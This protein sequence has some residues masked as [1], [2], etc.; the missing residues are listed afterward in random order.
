MTGK[1][2]LQW[3]KITDLESH[4]VEYV[5]L[6]LATAVITEIYN[7]FSITK[8]VITQN[9]TANH[10]EVVRPN[11]KELFVASLPMSNLATM[12]KNSL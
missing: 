7:R 1:L 9:S 2:V 6:D 5:K 10:N 11:T 8:L 4:D 3:S 12:I